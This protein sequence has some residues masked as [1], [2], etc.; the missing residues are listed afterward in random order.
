LNGCEY[1]TPVSG[2]NLDIWLSGKSYTLNRNIVCTWTTTFQIGAKTHEIRF[3]RGE[4]TGNVWS[5]TIR[6]FTL[7]TMSNV[8]LYLECGGRL[9]P[10]PYDICGVDCP[11]IADSGPCLPMTFGRLIGTYHNGG[12]RGVAW[13]GGAIVTDGP[14]P[15]AYGS[16]GVDALTPASARVPLPCVHLG[17]P[18]TAAERKAAGLAHSI[19]DWRWCGAGLGPVCRCSGCGP[20]CPLYVA[21][22]SGSEL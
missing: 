9:L 10:P 13:D 6:C 15:G 2:S 5:L 4:W 11:P 18:L 3:S 20:A 1:T 12:G 16:P 7:C 22:P 19:K 21:D 17:D 14:C 8:E